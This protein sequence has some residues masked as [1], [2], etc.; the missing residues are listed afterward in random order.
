MSVIDIGVTVSALVVIGVL[1]WFFFGPKKAKEAEVKGGVHQAIASLRM[2]LFNS[3]DPAVY[4][5]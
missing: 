1:A 2:A 4:P 5:P 3:G